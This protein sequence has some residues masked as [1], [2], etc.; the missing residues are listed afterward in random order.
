[1]NSPTFTILIW[2]PWSWKTTYAKQLAK[3]D[4]AE[5]LSSD[6]IRKQLYGKEE[7]Q[8]KSD[9]IFKILNDQSLTFLKDWKSVIYDATNLTRE[10]RNILNKLKELEIKKRAIVVARPY[11]KC[12]EY[13]NNR[14]RVVPENIMKNFYSKFQM[15][16]Y[17]E[18]FDE[19]KIYFPD[20]K[21]K[22]SFW[23]YNEYYKSVM[24]YDQNNPWHPETLWQHLLD[25][26]ERLK[27]LTSDKILFESA[28]IHDCW[29][30]FS[31]WINEKTGYFNFRNHANIWW[32]M[33]LFF[34]WLSDPVKT[35]A[36]V[37]YHNDTIAR[38]YKPETAEEF[39]KN[40]GD[41]FYQDMKN[42][43]D[44]DHPEEMR[45]KSESPYLKK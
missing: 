9:E 8:W 37:S 29:K 39:R 23:S 24:N 6:D 21:D 2:L 30:P 17:F 41:D 13:N 33:S 18:W 42:F 44:A 10:D 15:P 7:I 22:G 26:H 28:L 1:M 45:W 36:I 43:W 20:E 4:L 32:Y 34:E 40:V 3:E 19:I 38:Q 11:E 27:P 16:Y 25:V 5:I 14:D 35:A 12:L 31:Q